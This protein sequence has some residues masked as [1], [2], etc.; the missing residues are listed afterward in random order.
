MNKL[1]NCGHT[2][3]QVP[4]Y[5]PILY[6]PC[7]TI[8]PKKLLCGH[9][10]QELCSEPCTTSCEAPT[11]KLLFCGHSQQGNCSESILSIK[12]E[13]KCQELLPCGHKCN[14]TCHKCFQGSLHTP[15]L[16]KCTRMY[17]CGHICQNKCSEPCGVC[18]NKC[19]YECCGKKKC[20][21]KCSELCDECK[22]K[23]KLACKHSSCKRLCNEIC[24]RM[25]C[26]YE[27]EKLLICGHRCLG[28]CGETCLDYCRE[29]E[30]NNENFKVFFG[31]ENDENARFYAL[32]CGH[33]YEITA[34]DQYM[35]FPEEEKEDILKNRAIQWKECPKC[36]KFI[37][38][39]NRYQ[40]QIK[41]KMRLV[42]N[43]RVKVLKENKVALES[44][45]ELKSEAINLI[46]SEKNRQN[47]WKDVE[48]ELNKI[49]VE[50]T[51][52]RKEI[53]RQDYN[54]LY[55][56]IKFYPEYK[57]LLGYSESNPIKN[58]NLSQIITVFQFQ[59]KKLGDYYLLNKDVDINDDQWEK[60]R[61]KL[62]V[63]VIFIDLLKVSAMKKPESSEIY[64]NEIIKNNFYLTEKRME[65]LRDFCRENMIEITKPIEIH[66]KM[67][68]LKENVFICGKGHYFVMEEYGDTIIKESV[69]PECKSLMGT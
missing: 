61:Q 65:D 17:M 69:C 6:I 56:L 13:E 36:R 51:K 26:D 66:K 14:G 47:L 7:Q 24:D 27:C 58:E 62:E 55:Y 34:L 39:S 67:N 42:S 50:A 49:A 5:R 37:T 43:F 10:C 54:N 23:C 15:C 11:L 64:L 12:C 32:Q 63:L 28:L 29:C 8:C 68:F 60:V 33:F 20:Q 16:E 1:L 52:K 22:N 53:S 46:K 3:L 2:A 18:M 25:P 38:K 31:S 21:K 59:I 57:K 35:G 40:Q 9:Q 30:P 45:L 44:L 48:K 4:C 41:E 19:E